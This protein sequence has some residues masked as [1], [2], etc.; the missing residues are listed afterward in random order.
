MQIITQQWPVCENDSISFLYRF[1]K[2]IKP[3]IQAKENKTTSSNPQN[4]NQ[5]NKNPAKQK[6]TDYKFCSTLGSHLEMLWLII[7]PK[8]G[9]KKGGCKITTEIK[10]NC[11]QEEGS[12]M[13]LLTRVQ[14]LH[15]WL[16]KERHF[17]NKSADIFWCYYYNF[18]CKSFVTW[19]FSYYYNS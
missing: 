6:D 1:K 10:I 3:K 2:K 19:N 14:K 18:Y 15:H 13:W 9:W 16:T 12:L 8:E 17:K 11:L 4:P 7:H 5:P